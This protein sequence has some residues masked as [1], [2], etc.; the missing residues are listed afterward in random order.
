M[1]VQTEKEQWQEIRNYYCHH[2]KFTDYLVDEINKH[3]QARA[4]RPTL[5]T[6]KRYIRTWY[7]ELL[8]L[9]GLS[10]EFFSN[11]ML[12]IF[13]RTSTLSAR[14]RKAMLN[15]FDQ[16]IV[17]T[18]NYVDEAAK[19]ELEQLELEDKSE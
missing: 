14:V 11:N 2:P 1:N 15:M 16:A 3:I 12:K 7:D 8:E 6:D 18:M 19:K 13:S 5:G 9:D 4:K 10:V 17:K